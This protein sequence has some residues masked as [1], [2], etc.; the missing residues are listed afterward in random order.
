MLMSKKITVIVIALFGLGAIVAGGYY[1]F[2]IQPENAANTF[3]AFAVTPMDNRAA[4]QAGSEPE[5]DT[6]TF[7]A[8]PVTP[9]D[10]RSAPQ[11]GVF[12]SKSQSSQ[13][14]QP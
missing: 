9:M 5:S 13:A 10:T 1:F 14:A 4:P 12:P 8:F 6:N 2:V 3:K 7:K 11:V